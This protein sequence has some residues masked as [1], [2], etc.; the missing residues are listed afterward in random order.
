[1][2]CKFLFLNA[3]QEGFFSR[4]VYIGQLK[5]DTCVLYDQ[6]KFLICIGWGDNFDFWKMERKPP[7]SYSGVR[8]IFKKV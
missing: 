1:M 4:F 7:T 6:A 3:L 2:F 5:S 8:D